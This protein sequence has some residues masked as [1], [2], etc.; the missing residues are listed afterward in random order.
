MIVNFYHSHRDEP[1]LSFPTLEAFVLATAPDYVDWYTYIERISAV[2]APFGAAEWEAFASL[3]KRNLIL[4]DANGSELSRHG[5]DD[6]DELTL[7]LLS[8]GL[9]LVRPLRVASEVPTLALP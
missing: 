6:H 5:S 8:D 2:G 4:L 9:V 1:T 3:M 7:S